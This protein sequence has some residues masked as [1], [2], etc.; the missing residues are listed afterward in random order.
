MGRKSKSRR[1]AVEG[2]LLLLAV[3]YLVFFPQKA[4][5]ATLAGLSLSVKTVIPAVFPYLV[6][7]VMFI[8]TGLADRLAGRM[9][10]LTKGLFGLPGCCGGA[11]ILGILCGFPVGARMAGMLYRRGSINKEQAA[12]LTAFSDFCGPP[13]ILAVFGAGILSDIRLGLAV[14]VI[15]TVLSLIAGMILGRGKG[16]QSEAYLPTVKGRGF[17]VSFTESVTSSAVTTLSICAYVTFFAVLLSALEPLFACI[18]SYMQA[19]VYGFFE[20]SGGM[21]RLAKCSAS[22]VPGTAI[23]L[24]SGLSV[25]FQIYA[26]LQGQGEEKISMMPYLT[27]RFLTL[28]LGTAIM[29]LLFRIIS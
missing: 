19:L 29:Y 22:L 24:W 25:F 13:Y 21:N 2:G 3:V 17:T 26:V 20:M 9:Q 15:Q 8:L 12:R 23:L 27:V 7:S 16:G 1:I 6:L 28:P 4:S 14:F 10:R 18:P 5:A 11:I